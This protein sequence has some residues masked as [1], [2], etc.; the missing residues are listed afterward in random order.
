M[1]S[2]KDINV[3]SI[4]DYMNKK[5]KNF[6]KLGYIKKEYRGDFKK[7][8]ESLGH[9][10]SVLATMKLI[11]DFSSIEDNYLA[12]KEISKDLISKVKSLSPDE[13]AIAALYSASNGESNLFN[14]FTTPEKLLYLT[15]SDKRFMEDIGSKYGIKLP[16]DSLEFSAF[17]EEVMKNISDLTADLK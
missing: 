10:D 15:S 7:F 5:I 17:K 14:Y 11:S 2:S 13:R 12:K 6:S 4:V 8:I 1:G 3:K 9:S 16:T